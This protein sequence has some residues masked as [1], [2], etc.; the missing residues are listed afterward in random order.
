MAKREA[1]HKTYLWCDSCRRSFRHEESPG[2][3]CPVCGSI[4]RPTGKMNAIL[5]GLMANELASSPI[6]TR[7]APPTIT[8][9][10]VMPVDRLNLRPPIRSSVPSAQ[11]STLW[12]TTIV[13]AQRPGRT[14]LPP[15]G[16]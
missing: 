6:I 10:I 9:I 1:E 8:S 13:D 7:Y 12:N 16:T 2:G 5:R 14:V 4:M 11:R 3:A 15:A